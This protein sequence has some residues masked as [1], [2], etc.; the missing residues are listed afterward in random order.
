[1]RPES[2]TDYSVIVTLPSGCDDTDTHRVNVRNLPPATLSGDTEICTGETATINVAPCTNCTYSWSIGETG[3][4]SIQVNPTTTTEYTVTVTRSTCITTNTHTVTVH[5]LPISKINNPPLSVCLG[6]TARLVARLCID[7]TYEWS[8]GQTTRA[9]DVTPTETTTYTVTTTSPDGCEKSALHTLEVLPRP[10]A[11]ISGPTHSCS[12]ESV[13][14]SAPTCTDCSYLWSTGATDATITFV[15][16]QQADYSVTVTTAAGCPSIDTHRMTYTPKPSPQITVVQI[17]ELDLPYIWPANGQSYTSSTVQ[18]IVN[19]GCTADQTLQLTVIEAQTYYLDSDDD[20]YGNDAITVQACSEIGKYILTP[21]DC[22]DSN[23]EIAPNVTEIPDDCIDNDCDGQ[24][25]D[26]PVEIVIIPEPALCPT[27]SYATVVVQNPSGQSLTYDFGNGYETSANAQILPNGEY[28]IRVSSASGCIQEYPVT[29]DVACTDTI[30]SPCESGLMISQAFSGSTEKLQSTDQI[31]IENSTI[32]SGS[33]TLRAGERISIREDFSLSEDASFS[34]AIEDCTLTPCVEGGS[35]DDGDHCTTNDRYYWDQLTGECGCAGEYAPVAENTSALCSDGIDNDCDGLVDCE[36]EDCLNVAICDETTYCE[37]LSLINVEAKGL[38]S[39]SLSFIHDGSLSH[40]TSRLNELGISE[41]LFK[42]AFDQFQFVEYELS[43][44]FNDIYQVDTIGVLLSAIVSDY[45][46]FQQTEFVDFPITENIQTVRSYELKNNDESLNIDTTDCE[47]IIDIVKNNPTC[48]E[49]SLNCSSCLYVSEGL[50]DQ[51]GNPVSDPLVYSNLF[52]SHDTKADGHLYIYDFNSKSIIYEQDVAD[53]MVTKVPY[54]GP[55]LFIVKSDGCIRS[56]YVESLSA[57]DRF[58]IDLVE[59]NCL[60]QADI[61]TAIQ[62]GS[63]DD[64]QVCISFDSEAYDISGD[65]M[66]QICPSSTGQINVTI[67]NG[68]DILIDAI[69]NID[70]TTPYDTDGDGLSD[71]VDPDIDDDG[72]LNDVDP[73]IDGD[74]IL[75]DADPTPSGSSQDI[76]GDGHNNEEDFDID[77]DMIPNSSDDDIDGD[78]FVNDIDPDNDG[79]G[80][81]DEFD[82]T[83]DGVSC[84]GS[85]DNGALSEFGFACMEATIYENAPTIQKPDHINFKVN[86]DNLI[87]HFEDIDHEIALSDFLNDITSIIDIYVEDDIYTSIYSS[88]DCVELNQILGDAQSGVIIF[89]D[90]VTGQICTRIEINGNVLSSDMI[91]PLIQIILNNGADLIE[92]LFNA[93]GLNLLEAINAIWEQIKTSS[94]DTIVAAIDELRSIWQLAYSCFT[95]DSNVRDGLIPQC[96]WDDCPDDIID[97]FDAGVIDG[98]WD[99]LLLVYDLGRLRDAWLPTPTNYFYHTPQAEEIRIKTK[100]FMLFFHRWQI[101]P[102]FRGQVLTQLGE[103]ISKWFG[104]II[105]VDCRAQYLQGKLA[106]DLAD[107]IFG[108]HGI[109]GS[110]DNVVTSVDDILLLLSK[111]ITDADNSWLTKLDDISLRRADDIIEILVDCNKS[112]NAKCVIGYIQNGRIYIQ[113]DDLSKHLLNIDIITK[114]IDEVSPGDFKCAFGGTLCFSADDVYR[115]SIR[116][117]SGGMKG[118]TTMQ[119]IENGTL[120]N[121]QVDADRLQQLIEQIKSKKPDEPIDPDTAEKIKYGDWNGAATEEVAD[122]LFTNDGY[123]K[124]D[125]KIGSGGF[126]GLYIKTDPAT[127]V[128]GV[129]SP[130]NIIDVIINESKGFNGTINLNPNARGGFEQ[131]DSRWINRVIDDIIE[132]GGPNAAMATA[133]KDFTLSGRKISKVITAVDKKTGEIIILNNGTH[134]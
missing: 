72:I 14:L 119:V 64:D 15:P 127:C 121:K 41:E 43:Q 33:V 36:D 12:G 68:T 10:D 101:D 52:Y 129:D 131:M 123:V 98:I 61:L 115:H 92:T 128:L 67:T 133:L 25:D 73:D 31:T 85:A 66:G 110:T 116:I 1:M 4:T 80:I 24:V 54:A 9:I 35:C 97:P 124:Y 83:P 130:C 71:N 44:S 114:N 103:A 13:T 20:G 45:L 56:C 48:A 70:V 57:E 94:Y 84:M 2:R 96:A 27:G 59:G 6:E 90:E 16:T 126:D 106:L 23:P 34:A 91:F 74:G 55:F 46:D 58:T 105:D 30:V 76:D 17:C 77:G 112:N 39:L 111:V 109:R 53:D 62:C 49:A 69:I 22:D 88:N 40:V 95:S 102:T 122:I 32:S 100:I 29:I 37:L 19:D 107:F 79:D 51:N 120:V 8:T 65:Q 75:N 117:E 21:G 7:C 60:D 93:E 50:I 86:P 89:I 47:R 132:T 78:G 81:L 99:I 26:M 3:V 104:E 82:P 28:T 11:T 42:T 125:G 87:I 38:G 118:T 134:P 63:I 18:T 108:S 113:L 5:P